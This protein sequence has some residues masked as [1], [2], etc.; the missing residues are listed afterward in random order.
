MIYQTFAKLY[1]DLM[2]PAMYD[3]WLDFVSARQPN[4]MGN[5]LELACGSGRLAVKLLQKGYQVT[6]FDLSEEMLSLA[7][8]HAQKAQVKLPLIQGDMLD[9]SELGQYDVVSCFAD[10]ICYLPDEEAVQTCFAEVYAHLNSNGKFLFDV[11][12]PYQTDVVY[13]GYMYN[14]VDDHQAFVWSSY[15]TEEAHSVEH[16]L[17]FFVQAGSKNR[18]KKINEIHHERTYELSIYRRLLKTVGFTS[19]QASSDFG[20]QSINDQST[21]WFFECT[22]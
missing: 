21:R 9:L 12:S 14:Y 19:V 8:A 4:K 7:D 10:S 17:T 13:P 2:D 15:Q 3:E 22:K 20:R 6:G 18:Y 16:D 1:D 11:I 5:W